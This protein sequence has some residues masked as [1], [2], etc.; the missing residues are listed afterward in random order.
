MKIFLLD[1]VALILSSTMIG[2]S[3]AALVSATAL[4]TSSYPTLQF[5]SRFDLW[6]LKK[7]L[8]PVKLVITAS[9]VPIPEN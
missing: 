8:V 6:W 2:R 7:A 5:I 4:I 3:S 1:F 9:Y